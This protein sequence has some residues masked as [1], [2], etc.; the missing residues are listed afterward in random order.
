MLSD[1]K[2]WTWNH[3][4]FNNKSDLE[5]QHNNLII[6]SM[7]NNCGGY[8]FIIFIFLIIIVIVMVQ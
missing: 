6:T 1:D 3:S 8:I 5:D 2:A 4:W 7:S